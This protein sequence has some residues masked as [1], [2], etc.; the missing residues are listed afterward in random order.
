SGSEIHVAEAA[1]VKA[2]VIEADIVCGHILGAGRFSSCLRRLSFAGAGAQH[3][4][5]GVAEEDAAC[6]THRCLGCTSQE[7]AAATRRLRRD[8]SAL[9][10]S[11]TID[12]W[13]SARAARSR[14][15]VA[16]E[17]AKQATRL[18]PLS[19][20]CLQFFQTCLCRLQRLLLHDD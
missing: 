17:A 7:A 9:T 5:N 13:N 19:R 10:G 12:A 1:G 11:V 4:G 8:R 16:E 18:L 6:D 20:L 15:T 3:A 2:A 14:C